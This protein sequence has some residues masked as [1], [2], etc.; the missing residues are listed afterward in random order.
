MRL[1]KSKCT[2]V[3]SL[4]PEYE[5]GWF[6]F[7]AYKGGPKDVIRGNGERTEMRNF[8]NSF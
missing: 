2:I 3:F 8:N 1:K 5:T 6:L 4:K 7:I